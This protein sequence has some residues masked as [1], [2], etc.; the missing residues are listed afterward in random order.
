[1]ADSTPHF[2]GCPT[3]DDAAKAALAPTGV[4][5]AGI[6]MS[7]ILLVTDTGPDGEPIGVSPSLAA[8]LADALGVDLKLI[9]YPSPGVLADAAKAEEWDIGNIGADPARA[10]FIA[11]TA[12]YSQIDATYLVRGDSPLRT[13]ADVDQPGIKVISKARAAYTLWLDR[14]LQHAEVVHTS[15]ADES[16]DRFVAEDIDAL[17]GLIPR[18]VTDLEALPGSRLIEGRFTAVQQAVGTPRTRD[19]A[20]LAYLEQF[21]VAAVASG[22]VAELIRHHHADGLSVADG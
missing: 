15:S 16:F 18:L 4:L 6:N 5:R 22:F 3:P 12:P 13:I 9:T 2:D 1:M 19:G 21:V 17:G 11:F 20:G 8:A 14:N 10:E 7:N